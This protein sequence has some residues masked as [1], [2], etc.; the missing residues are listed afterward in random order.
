ETLIY[1]R[2]TGRSETHVKR[3]EAYAKEQGMFRTSKSPDPVYSDT[4]ELDLAKVEP[5][6]AGPSRPQDRVALK[7]VKKSFLDALPGLQVKKKDAKPAKK[8]LSQVTLMP[9]P[10]GTLTPEHG[11]VVIAAI[12]SCT[13]TSNPSVL[14]AAGLV[15]KKAAERGLETK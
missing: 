6:L 12:T 10:M 5:S 2:L 8:E 9:A 7:D 11:R 15:A 14:V 13:N 1:L 4:L 3:V